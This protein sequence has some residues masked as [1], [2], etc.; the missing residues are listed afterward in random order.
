MQMADEVLNVRPAVI[1]EEVR[2]WLDDYRGFR[3]IVRNVYTY[4]FIEKLN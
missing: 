4:K 3:H 1:S 2:Q